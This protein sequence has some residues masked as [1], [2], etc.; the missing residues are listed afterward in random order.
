MLLCGAVGLCDS[1][2]VGV[3]VVVV[4]GVW[5]GNRLERTGS[6]CVGGVRW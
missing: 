2:G 6:G 4:V 5:L 3:S 1:G